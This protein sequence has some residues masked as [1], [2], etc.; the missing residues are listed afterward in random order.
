MSTSL[1]SSLHLFNKRNMKFI[2][3]FV[4]FIFINSIN[5]SD[6]AHIQCSCCT[7]TPDN[8]DCD[9]QV[10]GNITID[11]CPTD[12]TD[13]NQKCEQQYPAQCAQNNTL[14]SGLCFSDV[15][16][17]TI[18]P[19]VTTPFNG[20]VECKC[21]CCS[22]VPCNVTHQGDVI[23]NSCDQC[24]NRCREQYPSQCGTPTASNE[25][26]CRPAPQNHSYRINSNTFLLFLFIFA[27][28]LFL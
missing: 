18:A 5:L 9:V 24:P 2:I 27:K 17:T 11:N 3:F 8:P 20:P 15:S 22:V 4:T 16:T 25:N 12:T 28:E 23:A 19:P 21:S 6:A 13:N 10:I 14:V 1:F 26:T 7:N